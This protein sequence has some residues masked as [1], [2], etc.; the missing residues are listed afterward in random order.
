[1]KDISF[2]QKERNIFNEMRI[3][4][5]VI[6]ASNTNHEM[7][8]QKTKSDF[9]ENVEAVKNAKTK[10][11]VNIESKRIIK[12]IENTKSKEEN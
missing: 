7:N 8:T 5:F 3:D 11:I 4:V 9:V 2:K 1:M 12:K 6:N 10:N